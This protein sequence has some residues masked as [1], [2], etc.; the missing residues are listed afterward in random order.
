MQL[1]EPSK[2]G[3][4]RENGATS[5][6][7]EVMVILNVPCALVLIPMVESASFLPYSET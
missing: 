6:P 2:F 4:L 3:G 1:C 7:C 5:N